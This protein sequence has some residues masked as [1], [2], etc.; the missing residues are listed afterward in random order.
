M[1]QPFAACL[2]LVLS[3]TASSALAG[4]QGHSHGSTQGHAQA[5]MREVAASVPAPELTVQAVTDPV[6]GYNVHLVVVNFA[7][8][9]ERTGTATQ[10]V[11]GHAH[12]YV[13][14]VKIG[15]V[16]GTWLHLP[17]KLLAPGDNDI[18]ISLNDNTHR[19]WAIGGAPV[20]ASLV[21]QGR[22]KIIVDVGDGEAPVVEVAHGERVRLVIHGAGVGKLHFHGYNIAIDAVDGQPALLEITADHRGRFP[23]MAHAHDAV[24]GDQEK[25]LL[26]VDIRTR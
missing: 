14:G 15:R 4:G 12:L 16:Y 26:Y 7:F 17:D 24:L 8:S 20:Q 13:N 9:P 3:L 18:R 22:R 21:L 11:E 19:A 10:A 5:E 6:D 2:V 1:P 23:V 25:A